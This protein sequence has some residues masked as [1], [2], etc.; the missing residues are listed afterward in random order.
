MQ[1]SVHPPTPFIQQHWR[2]LL[3]DWSCAVGSVLITLQPLTFAPWHPMPITDQQKQ[4][5][6]SQFLQWG[7]AIAEGVQ[8]LGYTCD[9]FDPKT[10]FPLLS[11]PGSL[12]L[13]DVA[14][15]RACLHYPTLEVSGCW[16]MIHPDWGTGVYPS[17]I[18]ASA[19]PEVIDRVAKTVTDRGAPGATG[20]WA[21]SDW[22]WRTRSEYHHSFSG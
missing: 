8:Q 5:R 9:L 10:G 16:V 2:E 12:G 6:R 3:P 17:V 13:D 14:G 4:W 15:V 19:P 21:A 1:Y 7:Q 22:G 20:G 18:L 11:S